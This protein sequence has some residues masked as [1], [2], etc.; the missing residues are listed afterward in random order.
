MVPYAHPGHFGGFGQDRRYNDIPLPTNWIGHDRQSAADGDSPMKRQPSHALANDTDGSAAADY[1]PGDLSLSPGMSPNTPIN[2]FHATLP[3]PASSHFSSLLYA[4]KQHKFTAKKITAA[5]YSV[6]TGIK[7]R[8]MLRLL[9]HTAAQVSVE[10][11]ARMSDVLFSLKLDPNSSLLGSENSNPN[12]DTRTKDYVD[13]L[14]THTDGN[15]SNCYHFYNPNPNPIP[16]IDPNSSTSSNDMFSSFS[17][18]DGILRHTL[19]D[20]GGYRRPT[21]QFATLTLILT[22]THSS[23]P[24]L[25]YICLLPIVTFSGLN[26][27]IEAMRQRLQEQTRL[28]Q[29]STD[30]TKQVRCLLLCVNRMSC[31]RYD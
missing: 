31:A 6:L 17:D 20:F 2:Q 7:G 14:L 11:M 22:L 27:Q 25:I 16:K 21:D 28:D 10:T 1:T 18:G 30:L 8:L 29:T 19:T 12:A 13:T 9:Q 15:E 26:T 3:A 4:P 23:P 5:D 24:S